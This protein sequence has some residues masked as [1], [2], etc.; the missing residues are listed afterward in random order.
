MAAL[1][2]SGQVLP[3]GHHLATLAE[4]PD[5][6]D[7]ISDHNGAVWPRFML[8]D[9]VA[10]RLWH[11]LHEELARFQLLLLGPDGAIVASG[12]CAPLVWDGTDAGLPVGWD[13]QFER[14][15]ADVTTGRPLDTLG[16]LQIVVGAAYQGSG[17]S[18]LLVEAFRTLGRLHGYRALI[19]C[20]R[21]TWKDRYPLTPIERY[22]AWTRP[23]GQPFDPWIRVHTRVGGRI[24]VPSPASMRIEGSVADWE[25][26]TG[27]AFPETGAYVVP[28]AAA[29]VAIDRATDRGVYL[30][31]NVW[32]VHDLHD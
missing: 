23:D 4:R 14:T 21:P 27:M 28:R 1:A 29:T 22:A 20:V 7:A 15:V 19:A 12:N 31:P 24:A 10:D 6:D 30:D 26:W 11:H 32:I 16:A 13:D 3:T 5:L 18:T 25:T 9:P 17:L 8:Q 2:A